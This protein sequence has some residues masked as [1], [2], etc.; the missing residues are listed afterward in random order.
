[1]ERLLEFFDSPARALV[2]F[3]LPLVPFLPPEPY[4]SLVLLYEEVMARTRALEASLLGAQAQ[5]LALSTTASTTSSTA[6]ATAQQL[7]PDFVARDDI[8]LHELARNQDVLA[9]N[10][11][12]IE[13]LE[14]SLAAALEEIQAL[15]AP[16]QPPPP[17]RG[18]LGPG[19]VEFSPAGEQYSPQPPSVPHPGQP[20]PP[21]RGLLGS[22]HVEFSQA[23]TAALAIPAAPLVAPAPPVVLDTLIQ[24]PT[25]DGLE[26]LGTGGPPSQRMTAVQPPTPGPLDTGGLFPQHTSVVQPRGTQGRLSRATPPGDTLEEG[27][28]ARRYEEAI[29]YIRLLEESQFRSRSE[30]AYWHDEAAAYIRELEESLCQ[31]RAESVVFRRGYL[32]SEASVT[33]LEALASKPSPSGLS[34]AVLRVA[35][36][37]FVPAA[38]VPAVPS[39]IAPPS[40]VA[41][42]SVPASPVATPAPIPARRKPRRRRIRSRYKRGVAAS[43]H[44]PAPLKSPPAP[45]IHKPPLHYY[46]QEFFVYCPMDKGRHS[47]TWVEA[48][49]CWSS[50][51]FYSFPPLLE[52]PSTPNPHPLVLCPPP[53]QLTIPSYSKAR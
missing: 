47:L 30:A 2:P 38:L 18:S 43:V 28:S 17:T 35:A 3:T 22:G 46:A 25:P 19:H 14:A 42:L 53:P 32:E 34:G 4:D 31:A 33:R 41:A 5:I 1:M 24:P 50:P 16:G 37:S 36:P 11:A 40:T 49:Q 9:S 27:S 13:E 7:T 44:S 21:T 51:R 52:V 20:P 8:L 45:F 26:A 29:K 10:H 12:V 6:I 15:T 39:L 23:L 48:L